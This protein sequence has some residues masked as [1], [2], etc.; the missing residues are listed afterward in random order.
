MLSRACFALAFAACASAFSQSIDPLLIVGNNVGDNLKT[1]RINPNGTLTGI[2]TF[3]AG[4]GPQTISLSPDGRFLAVGHGT[5]SVTTEELR[6]YEVNPDG[7]LTQRLLT[8]V[9]DSPL[10]VLWVNNNALAVTKTGAPA[11]VQMFHWNPAVGTLTSIGTYSTGGFNSSLATTGQFLYA[12]D[13]NQSLIRAFRVNPDNTLQ[14]VEAQSTSPL[15]AV[16]VHT[17]PDGQFLY[18]AGGIS[19]DG[20]RILG[21][22]IL[23][24]GSL[25]PTN[26]PEFTSPGQSPKN[27]A[28][29]EDGT[30][31]FAGHGTDATIQSF[32]VNTATGVITSTGFSYDV[33]LQGTLGETAI[34]GSYLFATDNSS[35][36]DGRTGVISLRI[37]VDGSL[38]ELGLFPSDGGRP[39]YLAVW[40]G[41]PEPAG[42]ALVAS[43]LL[44][45]FRRR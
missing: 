11:H 12:N 19:G 8:L 29:T 20:R 18:G 44:L 27:F 36:I 40:P 37:N 24:D 4:D 15:F 21:Y 17:S 22:R 7:T 31:L 2:G 45:A 13:T 23:S 30:R 39:D 9:P 6:I 42:L 32:T 38:T 1:F 25:D 5:A 43:G 35:A 33:G 10:D 16:N 34:L 14:L 41:I 28:I 26:P 3:A